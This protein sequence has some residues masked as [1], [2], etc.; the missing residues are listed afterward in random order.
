MFYLWWVLKLR[1]LYCTVILRIHITDL[2]IGG[3]SDIRPLN[4]KVILT[5][6]NATPFTVTVL[7]VPIKEYILGIYMLAGEA[8][9]TLNG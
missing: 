5:I 8:V 2:W 4:T 3:K 9:E 7:I 1:L 6:G